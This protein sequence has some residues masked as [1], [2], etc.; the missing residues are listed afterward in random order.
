L[1]ATRD[2]IGLRPVELR[3]RRVDVGD[4]PGKLIGRSR[5]REK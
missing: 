3:S 2:G 1:A 5:A 4:G